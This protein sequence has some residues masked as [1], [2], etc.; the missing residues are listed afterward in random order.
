[1]AKACLFYAEVYKQ[2]GSGYSIKLIYCKKMSKWAASSSGGS[3]QFH[4]AR[5][6]QIH[7]GFHDTFSGYLG[8]RLSAKYSQE[9]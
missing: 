4:S 5:T 9:F 1:M 7:T 6:L 3:D 8:G 2:T